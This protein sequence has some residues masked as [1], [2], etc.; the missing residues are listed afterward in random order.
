MDNSLKSWNLYRQ[1]AGQKLPQIK[2]R[3]I[4]RTENE[5]SSCTA[6]L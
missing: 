4:C 5:G 3:I 6:W 1:T 2:F